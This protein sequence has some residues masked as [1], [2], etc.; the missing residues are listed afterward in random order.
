[1][2]VQRGFYFHSTSEFVVLADLTH[3]ES[4]KLTTDTGVESG[5]CSGL[6]TEPLKFQHTEYI[7]DFTCW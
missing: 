1:M 5:M 3:E 4:E 7:P 2:S 6:F